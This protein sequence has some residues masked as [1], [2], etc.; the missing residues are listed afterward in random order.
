[1][2]LLVDMFIVIGV[3]SLQG[4]IFTSVLLAFITCAIG[5]IY[6]I[7]PEL[8]DDIKVIIRPIKKLLRKF[9]NTIS[10]RFYKLIW[11]EEP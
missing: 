7:H 6:I 3:L 1:M 8:R 4:I 5:I 11:K 9:I 10:R 2:T